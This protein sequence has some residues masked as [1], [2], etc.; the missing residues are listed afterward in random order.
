MKKGLVKLLLFF[1]MLVGV[2][3]FS[4]STHAQEVTITGEKIDYI[5]EYPGI[6]PDH[7]L[8]GFKKI[9]DNLRFFLNRDYIKKAELLLLYSDKKIHAA[10][11]LSQKGK[12]QLATQTL[13]QAENDFAKIPTL[14]A[15]SKKQGTPSPEA[16]SLDLKLSNQKHHEIIETFLKNAPSGERSKAEATLVQNLKIKKDL[17]K[18]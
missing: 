5:L 2:V 7:P 6:L 9:R 14:I 12:W 13:I 3:L 4:S 1:Y 11:L 15:T 8:Y 17:L 10:L 18:L 16:L